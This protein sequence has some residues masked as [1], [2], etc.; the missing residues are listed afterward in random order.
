M[1]TICILASARTGSTFLAD[2]FQS[3]DKTCLSTGEFFQYLY[4][5]TN[6]YNKRSFL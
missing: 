3:I 5:K 4:S 6:R 1:K 2:H